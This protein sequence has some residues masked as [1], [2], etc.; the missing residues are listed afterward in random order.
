MQKIGLE[1]KE[2]KADIK[3][4]TFALNVSFILPCGQRDI[5]ISALR[6]N[7]NI[8]ITEYHFYKIHLMSGCH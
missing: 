5:P 1:N 6:I 4:D 2:D 7:E 3:A 8:K